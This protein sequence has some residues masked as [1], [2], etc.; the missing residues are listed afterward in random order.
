[1]RMEMRY[2]ATLVGGALGDTLGM[3]VEGWKREQIQKYFGRITEPVDPRFVIADATGKALDRDEY[4]KIKHYGQD[5]GIG[6]WTDDTILTVA[7]AESIVDQRGLNLEDIAKRQLAEY[8]ARLLPDGQVRGGFG[9]TT[10]K[11]FQNLQKGISPLQSGVMG[12]PGNAPAMKMAPLGLYMDAI[13]NFSWE[14]LEFAGR[15][16]KITHLDT[17][18]VVSGVVQALAVST[19]LHTEPCYSKEQF[20][21]FLVKICEEYEDP[22]AAALKGGSL[23]SRLQWV[24]QHQEATCE[25]AFRTLRNSSKVFESYPFALFMFQEYW[26][27]PLEGL[28]ETINYGGDCDTTGAIFGALAGARHGMV[29]P[30]DWLAVLQERERLERLGQQI[31]ALKAEGFLPSN[32]P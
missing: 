32:G 24:Q 19:L 6:G 5:L 4:G 18:S 16:G 10:R 30:S 29:F 9:S 3:P 20:L 21:Y 11:G 31:F 28:L 14:T 12:G 25:T 17:R 15:I 26:D 2:I 23:T 27:E 13:R 7:L 22:S 1:M 8:E